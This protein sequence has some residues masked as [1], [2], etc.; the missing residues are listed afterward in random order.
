MFEYKTHGTCSTQIDLEIDEAGVITACAIQ[1]ATVGA[2]NL[3]PGSDL[4]IM[5]A[6]QA[7]LALDI[8]GVDRH[9]F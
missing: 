4:P 2:I 5:T 3:I 8:A 9:V 7:K 6:N 1:N